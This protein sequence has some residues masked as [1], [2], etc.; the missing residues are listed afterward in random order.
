[1]YCEIW[2]QEKECCEIWSLALGK[3]EQSS[4]ENIECFWP[5]FNENIG[6]TDLL[7]LISDSK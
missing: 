3:Y 4:H 2:S 5:V 1:M 6:L 7:V